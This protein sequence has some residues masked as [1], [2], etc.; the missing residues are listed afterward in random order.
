MTTPT[1]RPRSE[2]TD[3]GPVKALTRLD[4]DKV[5]GTA[6]HWP[7]T[8]AAIG[9]SGASGTVRRLEGYRRFHTAAPPIGKGWNDIAYQVAIDQGGRIYSA[10]GLEWQ[11]AA[12]GTEALNE[13]YVAVLLLV[14]PGEQPSAAMLDSFRWLRQRILARYPLAR[15]VVGHGQIRPKGTACPGPLVMAHIRSG[16]LARPWGGAKPPAEPYVLR[17]YLSRGSTGRAVEELQRRLNRDLPASLDLRV[18]G[19]FGHFTRVALVDWQRDRH[20]EAD[21]V[22]GPVFCKAAGWVWRGPK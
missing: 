4:P 16:D 20:L 9:D 17:Q 14:G 19:D 15:K 1:L 21:G 5:I 11:S 10:R 18:D 13:R 3:R 7:G 22:A 12:N 6:I 2:W 8:T